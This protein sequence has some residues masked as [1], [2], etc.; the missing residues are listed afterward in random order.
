MEYHC[1]CQELLCSDLYVRA[2][3][4]CCKDKVTGLD[5]HVA[6]ASSHLYHNITLPMF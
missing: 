1:Y 6:F 2:A 3:T 4:K 5:G